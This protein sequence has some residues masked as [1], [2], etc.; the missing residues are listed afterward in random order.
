[1]T[2]LL[3]NWRL[4]VLGSLLLGLGIQTWRLDRCKTAFHDYEVAVQALGKA[5]LAENERIA[6]E[7]E[8]TTKGVLD[9]KDAKLADLS[10]RYATARSRLRDNPGGRAVPADPAPARITVTCESP[11]LALRQLADLEARI[12]DLL[13]R[14]DGEM[15]K[16]RALW[17]WANR[18]P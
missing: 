14:A 9:A 7:R 17:E 8:A 3:A 13:E 5:Q 2:F 18:V 12:L 6:R 10:T 15:I 1:M 16:Y 4:L 11:D